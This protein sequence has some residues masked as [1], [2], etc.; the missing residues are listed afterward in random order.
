MGGAAK[1]ANHAG[2]LCPHRRNRAP[3]TLVVPKRMSLAARDDRVPA[4]RSG[5][6]IPAPDR[7]YIHVRPAPR[8][9]AAACAPDAAHD[10]LPYDQAGQSVEI[11]FRAPRPDESLC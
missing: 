5:A 11:L 9:V 6:P 1:P 4:V 7:G 2:G 8:G 10:R 3:T